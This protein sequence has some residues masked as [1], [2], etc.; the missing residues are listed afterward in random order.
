[1]N[2]VLAGIVKSSIQQSTSAPV[3]T[4]TVAAPVTSASL[5]STSTGDSYRA[6][7]KSAVGKGIRHNFTSRTLPAL[8]SASGPQPSETKS[9]AQGQRDVS[10]D[11][12]TQLAANYRNSLIDHQG[13]D[14]GAEH[15]HFDADPTPL[16]QMQGDASMSSGF[17]SRDPSLLELAMIPEV[18]EGGGH[19]STPGFSFVDFPNPEVRPK[20]TEWEDNV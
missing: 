12:L 18:E 10:Q 3:A 19:E 8:P 13:D 2:P 11:S 6:V 4:A 20:S 1:M 15:F 5:E 7:A 17:F 14:T 16:S 9:Q